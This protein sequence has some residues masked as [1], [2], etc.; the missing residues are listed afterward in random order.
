MPGEKNTAG[1]PL[2]FLPRMKFLTPGGTFANVFVK[3][4][5]KLVKMQKLL[6]LHQGAQLPLY[7]SDQ[8]TI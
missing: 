2:H 1:V 3:P 4:V 8:E 6:Y 7:P 5:P